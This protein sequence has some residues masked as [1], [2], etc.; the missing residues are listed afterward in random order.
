[1][2]LASELDL[3]RRLPMFSSFGPAQ[4]KLLCFSSERLTFGAGE[5]LFREGDNPDAAYVL[6]EGTVDISVAT[7]GGELV[8]NVLGPDELVGETGIFG[9]VPRTATATARTRVEALRVSRDLFCEL[10]RDNAEAA[11][12]LNRLLARRLANTTAKLGAAAA[13]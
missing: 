12:Q 4:Q 2:S 6:I 11:L 9:E 10:V 3:I 8:I 7:P 13:A 1:M 5:L